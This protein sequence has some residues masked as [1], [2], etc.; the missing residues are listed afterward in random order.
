VGPSP[1]AADVYD[2]GPLAPWRRWT[3]ATGLPTD[4]RT[5]HARLAY[6]AEGETLFV[7]TTYEAATR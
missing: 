3:F 5:L 6:D 7:D 1:G 2:S 4:G